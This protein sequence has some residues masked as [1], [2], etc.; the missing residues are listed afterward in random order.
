MLTEEIAKHHKDLEGATEGERAAVED[1]IAERMRLEEVRDRLDEIERSGENAFK[2][3]LS[4]AM[5]FDDALDSVLIS[6]AEMAAS[7]AWDLLWGGGSGGGGLGSLLGGL[8][9]LG[10]SGGGT[11]GLGLPKPYAEG[12]RVVGPGGPRD[13]KVPAWLSNDEFVVN[14]AAAGPAMPFLEAL[15]AGVPIHRLIEMIGGRVPAFADGGAVSASG[16]SPSAWGFGASARAPSAP[17]N[18]R[19]QVDVRC[20]L[21]KD[22]NLK[23]E[24][25]TIATNAAVEVSE[26]TIGEWSR[27]ALPSRVAE[28]SANPY[29]RG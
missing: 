23:A 1:L 10:S 24:I 8:L 11:G 18:D 6:L 15:N 14:A 3:L 4:G 28:I 5:S 22:L 2:G 26:V 7:D 9:G 20:Y 29:V 21:D 12:G 25:N 19:L 13:D 16:A 27:Q 17:S